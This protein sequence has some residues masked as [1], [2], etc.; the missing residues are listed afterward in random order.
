MSHITQCPRLPEFSQIMRTNSP[1]WLRG[2]HRGRN[3][4]ESHERQI[5]WMVCLSCVF[6]LQWQL[7]CC[8]LNLRR[9]QPWNIKKKKSFRKQLGRAPEEFCVEK[10]WIENQFFILF[11][12]KKCV[13][14]FIRS[15][16]ENSS[17]EGYCE[18]G[19][20]NNPWILKRRRT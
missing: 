19:I 7:S 18:E 4:R 15:F 20:Q 16:E 13:G 6:S 2:F 11:T 12:E 17:D 9:N 1:P 5:K 3:T 10:S 14:I 8:L